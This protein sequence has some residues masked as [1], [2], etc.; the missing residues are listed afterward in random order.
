MRVLAFDAGFTMGYGALGGGR[1]PTSGSRRLRGDAR[2]LGI[3]GRHCDS[4]VRELILAEKPQVIVF[5]TPFVGQRR[6]KPVRVQG[7]LY[8]PDAAP[9]QP[10]SIRPLMS[11]LT[12]IEM[13]CD[14]LRI[15]CLEL[16]EPEARRAFLGKAP[17]KSA[18]IKAAVMRE[19]RT[20]CWPCTDDHAGDALCVASLALEIVAPDGAL[21]VAPLFQPVYPKDDDPVRVIAVATIPKKRKKK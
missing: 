14:E 9:V 20:R 10:D 19:C 17:Q 6:G 4:V 1:A 18:D 8:W 2:T 7:R 3:A 12:I 5:A 13:V 11:F 15:R 16:S 21:Q